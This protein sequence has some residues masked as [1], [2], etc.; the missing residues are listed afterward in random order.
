MIS[1]LIREVILLMTILRFLWEKVPDNLNTSSLE[2]IRIDSY[3]V[4]IFYIFESNVDSNK[5]YHPF[6]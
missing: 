4:T 2:N 3:L 6:L 5:V 1:F